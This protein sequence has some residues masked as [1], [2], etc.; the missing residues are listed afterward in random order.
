MMLIKRAVAVLVHWLSGPAFCPCVV[1]V[2]VLGCVAWAWPQ[3]CIT[4]AW[5]H[6][7]TIC[8]LCCV[9]IATAVAG[10]SK[11]AQTQPMQPAG[12]PELKPVAWILRAKANQRKLG[13][14]SR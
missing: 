10:P 14:L 11:Q 13:I 3:G 9:A 4:K 5:L 6:I 2:V 8:Q 7:S 1:F 12:R